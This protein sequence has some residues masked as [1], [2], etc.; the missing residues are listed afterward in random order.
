MFSLLLSLDHIY[1]RV[2]LLAD[3]VWEAEYDKTGFF[4][5]GVDNYDQFFFQKKT[6]ILAHGAKW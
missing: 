5:V 2:E 6:N 3:G 4:S 1:N